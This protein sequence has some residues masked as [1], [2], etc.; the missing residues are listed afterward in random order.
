VWMGGLWVGGNAPG[1]PN[2]TS[3]GGQLVGGINTPSMM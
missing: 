2:H 3:A 1:A